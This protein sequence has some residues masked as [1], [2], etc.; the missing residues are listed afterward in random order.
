MVVSFSSFSISLRCSRSL[1][2]RWASAT[3]WVEAWPPSVR[4]AGSA[5]PCD[6][7]PADVVPV[8]LATEHPLEWYREQHVAYLVISARDLSLVRDYVK[9]GP[10]VFEI[11]PSDTRWGPPIRVV[12]LQ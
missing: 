11:A 8:E 9:A 5:F 10:V 3:T 2:V 12:R 1:R 7:P 6:R 4:S